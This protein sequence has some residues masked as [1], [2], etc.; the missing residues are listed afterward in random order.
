MSADIYWLTLTAL[1]TAL[2]WVPYILNRIAVRGLIG[3]TRNPSPDA[4]PHAPWAE[5][6]ILAHK[7]AVENLV[8]FAAVVLAADAA[9][10]SNGLTA[11]AAMIV[12]FARVAHYA[13]YIAGVPF[14]RTLAFAA[15]AFAQIAIAL[16]ALGWL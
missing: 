15:G 3:A 12:F 2:M 11:T 13:I 7:N 5:R 10:A 16:T 4:K 6:A 8:I 14:L 1:V 9:G